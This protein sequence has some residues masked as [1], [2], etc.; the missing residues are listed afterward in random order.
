MAV[1]HLL[2]STGALHQRH[3]AA[4]V[5]FLLASLSDAITC[6]LARNLSSSTLLDSHKQPIPYPR[7]S[8]DIKPNPTGFPQCMNA[9]PRESHGNRGIP[10]NPKPMQ[11]SNACRA[12]CILLNLL[13][14]LAAG[15]CT[16]R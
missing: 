6:K 3:R 13:L 16:L 1:G 2:L 14:R 8:R 5:V 10:I 11:A 12:P 7:D 4:V 9:N 15:G